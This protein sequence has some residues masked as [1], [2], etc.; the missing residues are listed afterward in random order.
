MYDRSIV[1]FSPPH[2]L[3][4]SPVTILVYFMF[5]VGSDYSDGVGSIKNQRRAGEMAQS[6]TRLLHK[7]W[8]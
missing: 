8:G 6:V 1:G 7:H 2:S 3:H 5:L 4:D